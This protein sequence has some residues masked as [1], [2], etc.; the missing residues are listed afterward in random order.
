[1]SRVPG[2]TGPAPEAREPRF[3]LL[4]FGCAAAPLFW[5]GQL[6]LA[7]GVTAYICYPADHP[8]SLVSAG[9]LFA[10]IAFDVAALAG[11]GAGAWVSWRLWTRVGGD[12]GRNHFLALWGLMSS[13]WFFGAILFNVIASLMVPSCPA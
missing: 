4:L 1:M 3:R 12:D 11:C 9:P 7:Y 6:M 5:L 10:L 8:V 2:A 13:L